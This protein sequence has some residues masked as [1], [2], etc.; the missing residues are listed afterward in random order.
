[1]TSAAD[2]RVLRV[3]VSAVSTAFRSI[4]DDAPGFVDC[5]SMKIAVDRAKY[6][7]YEKPKKGDMK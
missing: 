7:V 2:G 3:Q 1:M 4:I 6:Y 5:V